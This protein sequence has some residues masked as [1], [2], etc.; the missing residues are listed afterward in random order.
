MKNPPIASIAC[1]AAVVAAFAQGA[2]GAEEA[3]ASPLVYVIE[4]HGS[5]DPQMLAFVR[6][7]SQ[8]ARDAKA[9][10]IVFDIDTFGG[11]LDSTLEI[12]G[13][14]TGL[15]PA[16]TVAFI[17]AASTEKPSLLARSPVKGVS[18]SAGAL[19]ALSCRKIYMAPGTVIGAAAPIY[20]SP[21]GVTPA[22]EKV[23]SGLRAKAQSLAE[24]NGHPQ[25]I[26]LAMVDQDV[27]LVEVIVDGKPMAVT[28]NEL[29]DLRRQAEAKGWKIEETDKVVSPQGKLLTLT[30]RDAQYYGLSAGTVSGIDDIL[31]SLQFESPRIVSLQQSTADRIV[32]L[33]T[34][35]PVT[36]LLV[37]VALVTLYLEITS[38]G[39]GLPGTISII[40]FAVIFGSNFLLGR[41][42]STEIL[43]F[44]LGVVLLLVELF[45]IPGF[46]VVG[47]SGILLIIISLVLSMQTFTVPRFPWQWSALQTNILSVGGG[48]ALAIIVIALIARY[49]PRLPVV[50]RLLLS[51]QQVAEE[52][53]TVQPADA[54]RQ[55][56]GA[57]G[58]ATTTLRPAGKIDIGGKILIVETQGEFIERGSQVEVIQVDSNRILVRKC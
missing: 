53:Y 45:L 21:E 54:A 42:E 51:T 52:G 43:L 12:T 7:A 10:C 47:V 35:G 40:C 30:A 41:V 1:L 58:V 48:F 57:R 17:P 4:L 33:I 16:I 44:L 14:I 6:R 29:V 2:L 24:S 32:G 9:D 11:R 3:S 50:N 19:I 5:I 37:I 23:V 34:S 49:M 26:A 27:E 31:K 38:P 22:D 20:M 25:S 39:F 8:K 55:L 36:T 18:Y 56:V 15:H 28:D 13:T 46:G